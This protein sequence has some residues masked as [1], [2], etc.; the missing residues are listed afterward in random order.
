MYDNKKI[1]L[2]ESGLKRLLDATEEEIRA[3]VTY[4]KE[5]FGLSLHD[6]VSKLLLPHCADCMVL[7]KIERIFKYK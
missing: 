1:I 4:Y 2:N 7:E 3:T 5:H 6:E